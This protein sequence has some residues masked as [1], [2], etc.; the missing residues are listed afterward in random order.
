MRGK[1]STE[2]TWGRAS[3]AYIE[4][5]VLQVAGYIVENG[6]T[7]RDAAKVFRVSKS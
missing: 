5:R 4:E 3:D 6:A 7:V 2:R 1:Q